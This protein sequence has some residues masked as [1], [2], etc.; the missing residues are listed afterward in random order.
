MGAAS[1]MQSGRG[2]SSNNI[3]I[4]RTVTGAGDGGHESAA[5]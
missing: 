2:C 4:A 5:M 1:R 3:Q